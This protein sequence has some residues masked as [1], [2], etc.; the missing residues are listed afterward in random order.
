MKPVFYIFLSILTVSSCKSQNEN[1]VNLLVG[2]P[3]QGCEAIHEYGDKV[4]SAIDTLPMFLETEPK[5]KVSGVVYHK[6][7]KTPAKD[8]IL[9][10]YH[11]NREGLYVAKSDAEGWG[12]RHGMNRGWIKTKEDGQYTFYTFRPAAYPNGQE[13]EHIHITVK[14]P[15]KNEYYIEDIFFDDDVLLTEEERGSLK[16]RGGSGIVRPKMENGILT[17]ERNIVLGLN[18][19]NYD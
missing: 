4:L 13:P 5:L 6:D 14:E 9:Y 17:V 16:K 18:I 8:V 2:G 12:K 19:P 7:G 3:C 10:I 11:T 15:D 1:N